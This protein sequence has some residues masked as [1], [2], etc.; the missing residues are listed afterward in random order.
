[1]P[2]A[3]GNPIAVLPDPAL[4]G[5]ASSE[6]PSASVAPIPPLF[7]EMDILGPDAG[8]VASKAPSGDAVVVPILVANMSDLGAKGG[9]ASSQTPSASAAEVPIVVAEM[10]TDG[11]SAFPTVGVLGRT[12]ELFCR[13]SAPFSAIID[14]VYRITEASEDRIYENGSRKISE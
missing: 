7:I 1:M 10:T 8:T 14:F 5:S 12:R 11:R 2:N 13:L 9:A 3:P 6:A 4:T